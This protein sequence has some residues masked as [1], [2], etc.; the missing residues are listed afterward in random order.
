MMTG[1]NDERQPTP[2]MFR[3]FARLKRWFGQPDEIHV[4]DPAKLPQPRDLQLLFVHVWVTDAVRQLTF[5]HTIGMSERLIPGTSYFAELHISVRGSLHNEQRQ[6]LAA[7]LANLAQ[8]PFDHSE[9]LDWWQIQMKP[10]PIP[11]FTGCPH[12]MISSTP[13]LAGSAQIDDQDGPIKLLHLI[14]VTPHE[15]AMRRKEGRSA[16]GRYVVQNA[17]DMYSDRHDPAL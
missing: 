15:A 4:F 9:N 11:V 8:H 2:K 17:V 7:F 10:G 12:V 3:V 14:P 1:M 5:F 16:F 13:I 6:L